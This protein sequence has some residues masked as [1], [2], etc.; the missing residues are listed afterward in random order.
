MNYNDLFGND[1]ELAAF[2][3][4][5]CNDVVLSAKQLI[6]QN[7]EKKNK[8]NELDFHRPYLIINKKMVDYPLMFVINQLKLHPKTRLFQI[9]R[10]PKQLSEKIIFI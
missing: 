1:Y 4:N 2:D 3:L 9:G 6:F 8:P 5:C 7:F 10:N